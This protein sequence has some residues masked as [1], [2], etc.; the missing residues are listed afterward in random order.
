M[1]TFPPNAKETKEP[2]ST[3]VLPA[4][5]SVAPYP[6]QTFQMLLCWHAQTLHQVRFTTSALD[7]HEDTIAALMFPGASLTCAAAL[8]NACWHVKDILL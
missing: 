5:P 1:A 7:A 4:L 2:F 3:A 6:E 8:A